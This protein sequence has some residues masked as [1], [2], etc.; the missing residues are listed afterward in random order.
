MHANDFIF[1]WIVYWQNYAQMIM[2]LFGI[3]Q[4]NE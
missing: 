3:K 2:L 4:L 1:N